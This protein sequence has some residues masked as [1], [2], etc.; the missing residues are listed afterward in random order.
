[1]REPGVGQS[2]SGSRLFD[3]TV[4]LIGNLTGRMTMTATVHAAT[5]A[6]RHVSMA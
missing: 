2:A 3:G 5:V 4:T 1:M 6:W